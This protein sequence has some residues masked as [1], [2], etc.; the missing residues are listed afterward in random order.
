MNYMVSLVKYAIAAIILVV[1]SGRSEAQTYRIT[2]ET[3]D[4]SWGIGL[5]G[6]QHSLK[7]GDGNNLLGGASAVQLGYTHIGDSWILSSSIDVISGPYL[8]SS[9]QDE[10]LDYSGTGATITFASSAEEANVRTYNGNYGF[11]L[12][13]TY[14]D[15][16]GRVVGERFDPE[17]RTD[18]LVIRV[19][20]FGLMP[21]I[22]FTWLE[23]S[24]RKRSNRPEDLATR[25]EGYHLNIGFIF[26]FM[27]NYKVQYDELD[28]KDDTR[29]QKKDKGSLF[30]FSIAV[31][32]TA[33]LGV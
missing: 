4:D 31:S 27:A 2:D 7:S 33:L 10:K 26:P 5:L 22:F 15:I 14:M 32:F 16:V 11:A 30:G 8:A 23:S 6:L 9:K 19:T 25:I 29:R 18:N 13:I 28:T 12:G 24:A 1:A 17:D 20:N 3:R 21:S